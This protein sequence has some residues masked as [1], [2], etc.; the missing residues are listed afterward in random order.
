MKKV[1]TIV[2]LLLVST[3]LGF[4]T[5]AA[6][7]SGNGY[8]LLYSSIPEYDITTET[9]S[10]TFAEKIYFKVNITVF[11]PEFHGNAAAIKSIEDK[12]EA[13]KADT[14]VV[15][16]RVSFLSAASP[17]GGAKLND[18]LALK[19]GK[20]LEGIISEHINLDQIPFTI[21]NLGADWDGAIEAVEA[22]KDMKYRDEALRIMKEVPLLVFDSNGRLVSSRMKQMMDLD[23]G[24]VWR[25][26]VANLFPDL[27][28][29]ELVIYYTKTKTIV[30]PEPEPKHEEPIEEPLVEQEEEPEPIVVVPPVVVEEPEPM[31]PKLIVAAK[32]NL[33]YDA[34]TALN[35]EVE[36][37]IGDKYSV[38]VE[39][40]F[41]W[42]TWGP[43]DNKYAFQMWEI[44]IEPRWWFKRPADAIEP[45]QGMFVGPYVMSSK[46]DFQRDTWGCYQGEYWSAGVSA[47]WAW[48]W[49]GINWELSAAL[50]YLRSDY[51]H[52]NPATDYSVL[53]RDRTKTGVFSWFGPTKLKFSL[54]IPIYTTKRNF[55]WVSIGRTKKVKEMQQTWK[56]YNEKK[57]INETNTGEAGQ[58]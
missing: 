30:T 32:T 35:F 29:S 36:V 11:D 24:N 54:V 39:D 28:R 14:T 22:D 53:Y 46:Y 8:V 23:R 3:A 13:L 10:D 43:N 45:L 47:G 5:V 1:L 7:A 37:P 25:Y 40:V 17:E 55:P 19:R 9:S 50:G 56:E 31:E 18:R 27:R 6:P 58:E 20:T 33:L 48:K 12:I 21:E 57:Q 38:M 52:Y 16:D 15:I 34:V 26:M 41:P 42:W 49:K 44:G 51:R 4:T 2:C